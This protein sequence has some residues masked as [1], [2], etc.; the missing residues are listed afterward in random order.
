MATQVHREPAWSDVLTEPLARRIPADRRPASLV[1]IKVAHTAIFFSILAL[2]VLLTWDGL[3]GRPRRRT[4]IALGIAVSETAVYATNNQVCPL[5]PLAESLG[6]PRGS[7][8]DI[9][10]PDR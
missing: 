2:I 5:S 9:F 10:L 4:A 6:A 7:V 3:R 8:T 1:A